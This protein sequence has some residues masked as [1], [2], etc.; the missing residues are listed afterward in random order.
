M[1]PSSCWLVYFSCL[2]ITIV[3]DWALKKHFFTGGGGGG[4]G[5]KDDGSARCFRSQQGELSIVTSESGAQCIM[6]N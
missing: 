1:K 5:G 4:G 2:D 6:L 3:V